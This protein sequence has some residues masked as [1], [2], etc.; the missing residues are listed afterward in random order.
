MPE[1][2]TEFRADGWP[3]CPRCGEDELSS[4]I[5]AFVAPGEEV[6]LSEVLAG[7]LVCLA[8]G[9]RM[10]SER[11]I[12]AGLEVGA[13]PPTADPRVPLLGRG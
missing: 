7:P 1:R 11:A 9:H 13:C 12:A 4:L 6:E 3:F 8:C 10:L 2:F 5:M